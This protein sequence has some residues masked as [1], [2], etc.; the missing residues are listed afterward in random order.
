M[1]SQ[2]GCAWPLIGSSREH[3][4]ERGCH[5]EPCTGWG[6]GLDRASCSSAR[7]VG[8]LPSLKGSHAAVQAADA[9]LQECVKYCNRVPTKVRES[10]SPEVPK[11]AG[12]GSL[13]PALFRLVFS[14]RSNQISSEGPFHNKFWFYDSVLL[15]V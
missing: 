12:H 2:Q 6:N 10:L 14:K 13:Q 3:T 4:G 9:A 15:V 11:T 1:P 8:Y 7:Q 5:S